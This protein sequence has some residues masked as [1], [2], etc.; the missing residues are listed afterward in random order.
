VVLASVNNELV[1]KKLY[2]HFIVMWGYSHIAMQC[3]PLHQRNFAM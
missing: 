2:C 1:A 3:A